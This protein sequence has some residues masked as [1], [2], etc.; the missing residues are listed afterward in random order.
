[1]VDLNRFSDNPYNINDIS[2]AI[3]TLLTGMIHDHE[4]YE[5]TKG[6]LVKEVL[7]KALSKLK[8][9]EVE[10][11]EDLNLIDEV[12]N[13]GRTTMNLKITMTFDKPL[14]YIITSFLVED[15]QK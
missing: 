7:D 11:D 12:L 10:I 4:N 6:V 3:K 2:E 1:M 9:Y 14:E 15:K 5:V 8:S 13:E